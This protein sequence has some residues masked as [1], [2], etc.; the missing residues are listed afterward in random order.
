MNH[1]LAL[2]ALTAWWHNSERKWTREKCRI[3][4]RRNSY[5]FRL[6]DPIKAIYSTKKPR[7]LTL[8]KEHSD[9]ISLNL[10][11]LM[12]KFMYHPFEDSI[13]LWIVCAITWIQFEVNSINASNLSYPTHSTIM[14]T[15]NKL[16]PRRIAE[17]KK[18]TERINEPT[19]HPKGSAASKAGRA[20]ADATSSKLSKKSPAWYIHIFKFIDSL[21]THLLFWHQF[22]NF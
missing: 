11:W 8:C 17:I 22:S 13:L 9:E 3:N 16:Q 1:S 2:L 7:A 14:V 5:E 10:W 20:E 18:E 12:G 15:E 6:L 19:C 21:P 4:E